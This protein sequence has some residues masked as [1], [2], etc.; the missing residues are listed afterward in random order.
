MAD[1]HFPDPGLLVV[2][3]FSRHAQALAW[4]RGQLEAVFGQVALSSEPFGFHQ[5]AYYEKTM[6][7]GLRKQFFAF[8]D[9][10]ALDA[11]AGCKLVTNELE[12]QLAQV[13]TFAEPRPLNLDPGLLTLGKFMLATTKDQAHRIYL[14]DGVYAEV[15]LRFHAG[16]F[17]AWPWTYADYREPQVR[18]FLKQ[19][20][21][22]YRQ[23]LLAVRAP[24]GG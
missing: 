5:T 23:R 24:L 16:A 8:R 11:L 3:A 13:G 7:A 20:R 6:G 2:A 22:F 4:G 14:R 9:L 15:T 1:P 21:D 10:A 12:R 18:D 19:G 17:E